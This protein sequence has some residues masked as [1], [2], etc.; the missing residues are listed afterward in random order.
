MNQW[1]AS[2]KPLPPPHE[3]KQV[4]IRDTQRTSGYQVLVETGTHR[5]AMM[6]AQK[7]NFRKLY[8]IEL[9][10]FFF[11]AATRRFKNDPQVTIVHGDSG[12]KLASVVAELKE[13]AVFWLDGHYSSGDTAKGQLECPIYGELSAVLQ[14]RDRAHIILIDD[15]RCFQGGNDY[16][17]VEELAAY[18]LKTNPAYRLEVVDDVIRVDKK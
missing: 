17:T 3:V 6:E 15:A 9:S 18:I 4:I 2:S 10:D 8:S 5:G 7:Y 11:E 16:P 1:S 12:E 14:D 13:P